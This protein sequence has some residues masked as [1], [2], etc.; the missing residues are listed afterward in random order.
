M[1]KGKNSPE[2]LLQEIVKL[3]SLQ[4]LGICRILG[5]ELF[6]DE[7]T[8]LKPKSFGDMWGE[9]CDIVNEMNR[10]RRR[11]L[12]KLVYTATKKGKDGED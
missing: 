8:K 11:N 2:R 6:E 1:K 4:F 3:D 12:G 5:I 10:I 9:L 7:E